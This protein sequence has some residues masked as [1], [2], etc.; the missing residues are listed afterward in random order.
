MAQLHGPTG[1]RI[2]QWV[3]MFETKMTRTTLLLNAGWLTVD[4]LLPIGSSAHIMAQLHGPT[5]QRIV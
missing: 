2:A 4:S 3:L 5:G 1:Q